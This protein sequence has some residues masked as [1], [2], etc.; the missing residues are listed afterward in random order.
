MGKLQC[1]YKVN[2]V[3]VILDAFIHI[4]LC[5]LYA[6][7]ALQSASNGCTTGLCYMTLLALLC[8]G[9]MSIRSRVRARSK[10]IKLA[11][12]KLSARD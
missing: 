12:A 3:S 5:Y 9:I 8:L 6:I 10:G 4:M 7:P 1:I 11:Q 2:R